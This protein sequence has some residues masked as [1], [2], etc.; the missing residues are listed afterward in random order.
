[1]MTRDGGVFIPRHKDPKTGKMKDQ[2]ITNSIVCGHLNGHYSICVYAG[3][4]S[5][6]FICFDVDDGNPQTVRT[7]IDI[8]SKIGFPRER[9]YVSTSGGK[10]FHV[11]MFFS[12]L[13]FTSDLKNIYNYVCAV[14]KL[15]ATKVEFRPTGGQSIKLPLS[16]HRKTG[17]TCWYLDRE[18]LEQIKDPNYIMGIQQIPHELALSISKALPCCGP[19]FGDEQEKITER[20]LSDD[21]IAEFYDNHYPDLTEQGKRNTL[22]VQ[23]AVHNRYR[24]L[25]RDD[26]EKEL[27]CWY[28]RQNAEYINS[29]EKLVESE[30]VKIL[31]WVFSDKFVF[32]A[33]RE[34]VVFR[35]DDLRI[36]LAQTKRTE[37]LILFL[38][39]YYTKAYSSC[40]LSMDRISKLSGLS[41]HTVHTS[42]QS[43]VKNKW[44]DII[45]ASKAKKTDEGYRCVANRY[46]PSERS[47][48][49]AAGQFEY[50]STVDEEKRE[51]IFS[52][53]LNT[54]E[55]KI[56]GDK[57]IKELFCEVFAFFLDDEA[58]KQCLIN[59]RLTNKEK[60]E[61]DNY[62]HRN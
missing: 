9:I 60:K 20:V 27:R 53:P 7:I 4:A 42:I 56:S 12:S 41:V 47:Y 38:I 55:F 45:S 3:S 32:S 36:L 58:I 52:I 50:M 25:S 13:M 19:R 31:D 33:K 49:W 21:E 10:G 26:S 29:D 15:D 54:E 16:I 11:E 2:R 39:Q 5:S 59:K 6:K 57:E 24:G 35:R 48:N 17:N 46:R 62:V 61:I 34:N 43:L 51:F 23:I 1:M 14:G 37:R 44:V 40:C 18:T 8:L 22:M 28:H 30:I